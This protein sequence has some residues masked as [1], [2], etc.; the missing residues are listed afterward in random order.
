MPTFV[1]TVLL[2]TSLA[3]LI[4]WLENTL[5]HSGEKFFNWKM[6]IPVIYVP[7]FYLLGFLTYFNNSFKLYYQYSAY[8]LIIVSLLGL[9]YHF[10]HIWKKGFTLA[11]VMRGR[12]PMT[13]PLIYF[14]LGILA[15]VVSSSI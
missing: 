10:L 15:L 9:F 1:E 8:G 11:N 3:A 4:V 13:L 2:F 12:P 6:W 14:A 5:Q 7:I